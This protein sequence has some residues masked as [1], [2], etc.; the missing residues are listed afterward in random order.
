[1]KLNFLIDM[2]IEKKTKLIT[3]SKSLS[4]SNFIKL[5]ESLRLKLIYY[6]QFA[7]PNEVVCVIVWVS[8]ENEVLE[9][10]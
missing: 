2:K 9:M 5:L 4:N 6:H 8:V 1:M 7:F 3:A 10:K